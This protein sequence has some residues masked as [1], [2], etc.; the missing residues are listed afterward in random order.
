MKRLFRPTYYTCLAQN[1]DKSSPNNVSAL[2][3]N[4][5]L[6]F[7]R[8]PDT[9][10]EHFHE[11]DVYSKRWW[12]RAHHIANMF[13]KRWLHEYVPALQP[14]PKWTREQP[15]LQNTTTCFLLTET[16]QD[17]TGNLD[18]SWKSTKAKMATFDQLVFAFVEKNLYAPF[19]GVGS[20]AAPLM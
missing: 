8:R 4:L 7:T 20:E 10:P 2:T 9:P 19:F 15:S 11:Q 5:L 12:R 1:T 17:V 6:T 3:L 13:W 18:E 16:L 14:R